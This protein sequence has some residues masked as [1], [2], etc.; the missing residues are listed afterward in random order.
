M[1][2]NIEKK[3]LDI[4]QRHN[5][6]FTSNFYKDIKIKS[7]IIS[8]KLSFPLRFFKNLKVCDYACG[9]GENA[10]IYALNGGQVEG[11]DY[12]EKSI[13]L[14]KTQIKK[15]KNI[16][17]SKIK[18]KKKDFFAAKKKYD[19][20][21]CTA[22]LHHLKN[23]Y[24]GILF[25]TQ[26]VL[27]GGFLY[28]SF[29]LN[30]S[31][32]QHGLMKLAIRKFGNKEQE[33]YK[34]SKILYPEHIKKCVK[35]GLRN[36]DSVI[37]DQFINPQHYYLDI[38]KV[39]KIINKQFLL[40]SMWPKPYFLNGDS[41]YRNSIKNNRYHNAIQLSELYWAQKN[42]DDSRYLEKSNIK[43][44]KKEIN[45]LFNAANNKYQ[46]K[47][48]IVDKI[49]KNADLLIKNQIKF[50]YSLKEESTKFLSELKI[51]ANSLKKDDI[52]KMKKKIKSFKIL[53]KGTCGLGLN[54][55]I[56]KK[57]FN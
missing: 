27:P 49:K 25:L 9:T 19:F 18:F 30:S 53:F 13:L 34:N 23:P 54:Y 35:F 2:K 42:L 10:I 26:R 6:S 29:G 16:A 17:T 40:H 7:E 21:S 41:A 43:Q 44:Y 36:K 14:A 22:A 5:P 32:F 12:N 48:K 28:L 52:M 38:K 20:V 1:Y 39:F 4:Y 57:K 24:K 33:I 11:Y 8:E 50:D 3:V 47:L 46:F 55:F 15:F 45:N 37:Y 51:F 56:F 31:N